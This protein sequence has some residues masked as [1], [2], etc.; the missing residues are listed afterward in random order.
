LQGKSEKEVKKQG[1]INEGNKIID[2]GTIANCIA[3][4]IDKKYVRT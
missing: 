1:R 2:L 3:L 4:I